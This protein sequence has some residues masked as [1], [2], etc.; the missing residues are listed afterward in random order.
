[1]MIDKFFLV[2]NRVIFKVLL[3]AAV[4]FALWVLVYGMHSGDFG[5]ME[6]FTLIAISYHFSSNYVSMGYYL[7]LEKSSEK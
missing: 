6:I 5:I 3:V 7:S 1:M 4:L 2:F